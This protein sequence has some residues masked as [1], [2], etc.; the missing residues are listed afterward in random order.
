MKR[1]QILAIGLILGCLAPMLVR[2]EMELYRPNHRPAAELVGVAEGLLAPEGTAIA[3]PRTGVIVLKGSEEAIRQVVKTLQSLDLPLQ[4]YRV[5]TLWTSQTELNHRGLHID[6]WFESGSVRVGRLGNGDTGGRVVFRTLRTGGNENF[7]TSLSV[8]DGH[9]AEIWTG[10]IL[11]VRI[12]TFHEPNTNRRIHETRG[13]VPIRKGVRLRPRSLQ[14]GSVELEI[15]PIIEENAGHVIARTEAATR[16]TVRP[17]DAIVIAAVHQAH[18][19]DWIDVFASTGGGTS[20]SE[21]VLVVRV[22][23]KPDS[24]PQP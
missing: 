4:N 17:G 18:A 9:S 14:D 1:A 5:D 23:R 20:E 12:R 19:T 15:W 6:G 16:V 13:I 22:S 10:S 3:D 8:L 21:S 11:P 2:A 24:D 7:R